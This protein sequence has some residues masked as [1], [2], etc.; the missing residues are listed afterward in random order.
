MKQRTPRSMFDVCLRITC[1]LSVGICVCI[2]VFLIITIFLN[3]VRAINLEF[4]FSASKNF[5]S[6][7]GVLYQTIGSLL[8]VVF[9]GIISLPIALGT[10]IFKSE[11]VQNIYIQRLS[12]ALIFSLNG[13]PSIIFGVFGLIFF[14]NILNTG[15]SWI[16]GSIILACMILPTI[17]MT[18]Y[19]SINS[20]PTVYRESALALGL[21]K[22]KIITKVLLPHGFF[23]AI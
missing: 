13:V 7:G 4:I 8:L 22:W 20:V 12:S 1:S 15:I 3:G 2:L 6:T 16:I 17:V 18:T 19:Q 21:G 23:G 5:G 10:A 11:Y 9:A 14:V